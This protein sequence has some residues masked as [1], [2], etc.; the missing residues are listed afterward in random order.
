MSSSRRSSEQASAGNVLEWTLKKMRAGISYQI[1]CPI[2]H[3]PVSINASLHMLYTLIILY[4][5]KL[6]GLHVEI[7]VQKMT[8]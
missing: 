8:K 3:V 1:S 2:S 6:C 5:L 4:L 7:L